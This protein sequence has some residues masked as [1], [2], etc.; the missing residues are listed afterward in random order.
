MPI[1]SNKHNN[2]SEYTVLHALAKA[3][4]TLAV[5][6]ASTPTAATAIE[7]VQECHKLG[8]V[9]QSP[10]AILHKHVRQIIVTR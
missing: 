9:G 7:F 6:D 10:H 5:R 1:D 4:I 8:L 3:V 2:S